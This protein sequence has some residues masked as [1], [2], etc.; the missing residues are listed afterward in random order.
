MK[1]K[2]YIMENSLDFGPKEKKYLINGLF[3]GIWSLNII[4]IIWVCTICFGTSAVDVASIDGAN[5][6]YN[7]TQCVYTWKS[8]IQPWVGEVVLPCGI[9]IGTLGKDANK[10][11][12]VTTSEGKPFGDK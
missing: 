2:N 10:A 5:S 11:P 12:Y 6:G 4:A 9:P 7:S 3:Y 8:T 1:N